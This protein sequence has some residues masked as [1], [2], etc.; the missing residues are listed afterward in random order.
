MM[1]AVSATQTFSAV[2][3]PKQDPD[4]AYGS[5]TAAHYANKAMMT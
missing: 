2:D 4:I 5:S 3:S 1:R